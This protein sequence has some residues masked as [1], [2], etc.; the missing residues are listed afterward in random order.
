MD[1][2]QLSSAETLTHLDSSAA[3]L[4][5]AEVARRL[6]EHGPNALAE[7]PRRSRLAIFLGQ[8]VDFMI[9]VLIG[10]A[11]IAGL[12]GEWVDTLVILA[13]VLLSFL[14]GGSAY[15]S[16]VVAPNW[17]SQPLRSL[18]SYRGFRYFQRAGTAVQASRSARM[19]AI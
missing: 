11:L 7:A 15:E 16:V 1:W 5:P 12:I 14:I 10:A 2:H 4:T 17:A 18:A 13:I 19:R 3:G 9:I 6:A 8:F